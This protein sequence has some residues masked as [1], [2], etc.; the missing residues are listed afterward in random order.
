M[1]EGA[2]APP[3]TIDHRNMRQLPIQ[4]LPLDLFRR[5]CAFGGVCT[6]MHRYV[7]GFVRKRDRVKLNIEQ[8]VLAGSPE[9][10]LAPAEA[11]SNIF[12]MITPPYMGINSF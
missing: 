11:V 12:L 2:A 4:W 3:N 9:H 6:S 10:I 1:E 5:C 7:H 8:L